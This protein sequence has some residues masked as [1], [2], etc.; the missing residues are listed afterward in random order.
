MN[1]DH[2]HN[3]NPKGPDLLEKCQYGKMV[4]S[5]SGQGAILVGCKENPESLYE[6]RII[7]DQLEWRKM[8]QTLQYPKHFT[9]AMTV[10]DDLVNCN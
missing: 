5:P 1:S 4:T 9:V 6:L 8:K 7:N 10:P 2:N 3:F